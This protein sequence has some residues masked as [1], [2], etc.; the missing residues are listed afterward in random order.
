MKGVVAYPEQLAERYRALQL[1]KGQSIPDW[2]EELA[3]R[4]SNRTALVDGERRVS[5]AELAR[6]ARAV[7][8]GLSLAGVRA[9]D[10]VVLQLPN[11][12]ELVETLLGSM[13]AGAIPVL[14]LPAHRRVEL[15]A[16]CRRAGAVGLV[17]PERHAGVDLLTTARELRAAC[18]ELRSIWL[19]SSGEPPP[20]FQRLSALGE[21]GADAGEAAP[22]V[23]ASE[24]ALLQLS[25][26]STGVPKLIPR[27]HDDY[28]YSVRASAELC[29]LDADSRFLAML[30]MTH[31]FTLSSPGWLGVFHAG[32]TV[33]CAD[34][35]LP[36]RLLELLSRERITI[37]AAVPSLARALVE[38]AP[39]L[40]PDRKLEGLLLQVGGAKL[41]R[42][43]ARA[44]LEVLGC[45]LQQVFGMAEGLVNYTRLD[46]PAAVV[47]ETQGR[48][49]SP[50][51]ELRVVDP[52]DPA[53]SPLPSGAVGELQTRGPYTIRGYFDDLAGQTRHFTADGFYRTG[54]L[55]RRTA[56]GDLIVEGRIGE[57]I[58]R[59]GEKIAPDEVEAHLREHP[60][61]R[62]AAVVGVDDEYLGQRS[63]A[64]IS[65]VNGAALP[66]TAELRAF[67]RARG[68]AAFKL[69]DAVQALA[70]LP[71]TK[72]GKTD[73]QALQKSAAPR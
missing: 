65:V 41:D 42:K 4:F 72:I 30:P 9:L 44:V 51:D 37:A 68:L 39:R 66:T 29:A 57:R 69:P 28:L 50:Y 7:A 58:L 26:G 55:V 11:G 64:F 32:G 8:R 45:R 67:L 56:D 22:G 48:P 49:L 19:A 54:D 34:G 15:E 38:A 16:F 47:M 40:L 59:G 43:L 5:Y 62:D 70:E 35:L 6:R 3:A 17:M 13:R 14:A 27:T 24:V 52:D 63:H 60:S 73:K 10:R 2:F 33:L 31:N 1:W 25:G 46:A 36:G 71:R 61:V 12:L 53:A 23:S 20:G 21:A 18:A